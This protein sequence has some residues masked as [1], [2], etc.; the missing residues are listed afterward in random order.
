MSNSKEVDVLQDLSYLRAV[1]YVEA[2]AVVLLAVTVLTHLSG[3][4]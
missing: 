2:A 3:M 1:C 4:L